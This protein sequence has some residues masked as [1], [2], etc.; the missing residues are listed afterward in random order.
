M[1]Y[2]HNF[3]LVNYSPWPLIGSI[4]LML[5]LSSLIKMFYFKDFFF[6]F[7]SI[8]IILMIMYQGW[9][10]ISREST[11]QGFHSFNVFFNLK[12]G[13]LLF[14]ISEIFLFLFFW[15]FFHFSLCQL[16]ELGMKWPPIGVNSFNPFMIPLLNTIIL[17][18]SGIS[19]TW[20]HHSLLNNN[21][22]QFF[23]SLLITLILGFYFSILQL[24]EYLESSFNI[25][26]SSYGSMFFLATGFHGLHV[27]I[28]TIFL[29]ICFIRMMFIHFSYNHHFGFEAAAWYWHFVDVVWLFLYISIYWWGN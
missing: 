2:N 3:H 19:I 6:L 8:F 11:F 28:G 17:L 7:L 18:T 1:N 14:I 21:Y 12:L 24:Y 27:L 29:F 15:S 10:D 23:Y 20:S 16:I 9:R 26:D 5:L 4:S 25:S 22:K 13:M